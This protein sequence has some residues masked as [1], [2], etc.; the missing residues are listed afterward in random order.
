MIFQSAAGGYEQLSVCLLP[1]AWRLPIQIFTKTQLWWFYCP[2]PEATNNGLI[3][4]CSQE[5]TDTDFYKDTVVMILLSAAGGYE[6]RIDFYLLP[7]GYWYRFL[8]GH[9][10]SDFSVRSRRLRTTI[11]DLFFY[12][13]QFT[14]AHDLAF[15]VHYMVEIHACTQWLKWYGFAIGG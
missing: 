4:T 1:V 5:A 2:Q 12:L 6:Q 13:H 10:V 8:Q 11:R 7:G 9:S 15:G 14:S 3:F